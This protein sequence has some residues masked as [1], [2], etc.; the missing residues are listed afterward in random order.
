MF[1]TVEKCFGIAI[2][3]NKSIGTKKKLLNGSNGS[4]CV[5]YP[6]KKGK[7]NVRG[8]KMMCLRRNFMDFLSLEILLCWFDLQHS[9]HLNIMKKDLCVLFFLL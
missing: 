9:T 8:K 7:I 6:E 4:N 5:P 2:I 3:Q 1:Y